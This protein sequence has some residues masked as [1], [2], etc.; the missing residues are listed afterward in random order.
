MGLSAIYRQKLMSLKATLRKML[1]P[2]YRKREDLLLCKELK[3][4]SGQISS[5]HL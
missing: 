2:V 3:E 4:E 5:G 1:A